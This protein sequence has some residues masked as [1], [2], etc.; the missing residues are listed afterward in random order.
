MNI[1]S[2]YSIWK[3][4]LSTGQGVC[5]L[6]QSNSHTIS[7]HSSTTISLIAFSNMWGEYTDTLYCK[8]D[9]IEQTFCFDFRIN[10][11][12]SPIK[13]H[14]MPSGQQ[15]IIR[16]GSHL[17][18]KARVTRKIRLNNSS[19]CD[20]RID[21]RVYTQISD[22]LDHDVVDIELTYGNPLP[23]HLH[24]VT[25]S[26]QNVLESDLIQLFV[27][28]H[29]SILSTDTYTIEPAQCVVPRDGNI[30]LEFI[31]FPT[32][33]NLAKFGENINGH[34]LGYLSLDYPPVHLGNIIRPQGKFVEPLRI[35][36]NAG[37][38]HPKLE[39]MPVNSQLEE[40][41]L[42]FAFPASKLIK[43][44]SLGQFQPFKSY[45]TFQEI[46][47][48]NPTKQKLNFDIILPSQL[49]IADLSQIPIDTLT[50]LYI[51]KPNQLVTLTIN[52]AIETK[53]MTSS[54][55]NEQ[56]DWAIQT[57]KERRYLTY[58]QNIQIEFPSQLTQHLPVEARI[59]LPLLKVSTDAIN[60]GSIDIGEVFSQQF[61]VYNYASKCYSKWKAAIRPD[62]S[63]L[64][65][66]S[67]HGILRG[68]DEGYDYS[69]I[70]LLISFSP[71]E[72]KDYE[73]EVVITG[74]FLEI[75]LYLKVQGS[76][77]YR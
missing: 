54:F 65:L 46:T 31:F 16:F 1:F 71:L 12:G 39:I 70:T 17:F 67:D 74:E 42:G 48:Q 28:P 47:I 23:S 40:E 4:Y 41:I 22:Q 51:L 2:I 62:N 61:C 9:G 64:T 63:I 53:Q 21:W 34:A 25:F 66:D 55:V 52:F 60:F 33:E 68:F 59:E 72:E 29:D 49:N 3:A 11:I 7:P 69:A 75:P 77:R 6:A 58:K 10:V 5:F 56:T 57:K 30:T 32:P 36:F 8:I 50:N 38:I 44:N 27:N 37:I 13:F 15:P 45:Q 73:F 76:G 18:E 43:M 19:P 35:D 20:I 14:S 26:D 24:T